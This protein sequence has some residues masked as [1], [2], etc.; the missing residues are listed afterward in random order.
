MGCF[1]LL[2][3]LPEN[4]VDLFE[5]VH[6]L[7]EFARFA[8]QHRVAALQFLKAQAQRVLLC[9]PVR[10]RGSAVAALP[11]KLGDR[12][13]KDLAVFEQSERLGEVQRLRALGTVMLV[14]VDA[15]EQGARDPGTVCVQL[16]IGQAQ[17]ENRWRQA[18]HGE[19][20]LGRSIYSSL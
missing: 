9:A 18:N 11:L 12:R 3:G 15:R 6:A 20:I 19:W 8:S 2:H 16:L 4:Y 5:M 1:V 14:R 17:I 10:R 7:A 13:V